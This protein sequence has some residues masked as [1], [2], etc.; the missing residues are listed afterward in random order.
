MGSL[1]WGPTF[2]ISHELPSDADAAGP[3]PHFGW[4]GAGIHTKEPF[5]R[6]PTPRKGLQATGEPGHHVFQGKTK[7][8]N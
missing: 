6:P 1:Q 5:P 3:Q 4:Q 7:P 8:K 2:C